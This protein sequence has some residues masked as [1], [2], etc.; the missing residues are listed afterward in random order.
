MN[1]DLSVSKIFDGPVLDRGPEDPFWAASPFVIKIDDKYH[2]FFT[3]AISYKESGKKEKLHHQYVIKSRVSDSFIHFSTN[4]NLII[5]SK[6][7]HEYA[8]ARPSVIYFEGIYYLFY[9]KRETAYSRDYQIF[10]K[11]HKDFALIENGKEEHLEIE[12]VED[13]DFKSCQCYPYPF[14]IN[15]KLYLLYNGSQYGKTGFR[16]GKIKTD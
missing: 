11:S 12:N 8:I 9:C 6:S 13:D 10:F 5:D 2:M 1:Q 3:S 7:E 14:V 16:I 15:S 4:S